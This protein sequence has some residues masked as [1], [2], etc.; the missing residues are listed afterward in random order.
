[1]SDLANHLVMDRSTLTRNFDVLEQQGL[2]ATKVGKDRRSRL[3]RLTRK[4]GSA[5]TRGLPYWQK[6][7]QQVLERIGGKELQALVDGI[8]SLGRMN[9]RSWRFV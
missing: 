9:G 6:A 4:G 8:D 2:V 3:A 1:M 5:L 7:Q